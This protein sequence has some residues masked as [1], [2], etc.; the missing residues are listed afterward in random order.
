MRFVFPPTLTKKKNSLK[1]ENSILIYSKSLFIHNNNGIDMIY[2]E[3][4]NLWS[5]LFIY[6]CEEKQKR[7]EEN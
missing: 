7:N 4:S 5:H 1:N 6:I 3:H 2:A